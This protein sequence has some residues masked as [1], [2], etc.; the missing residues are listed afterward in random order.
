MTAAGDWGTWSGGCYA[1]TK[2]QKK[3]KRG[4]LSLG[5]LVRSHHQTMKFKLVSLSRV[6]KNG[7][8]RL[9]T[10]ATTGGCL[11]WHCNTKT[12][13]TEIIYYTALSKRIKDFFALM[14]VLVIV[15]SNHKYI[16]LQS[17]ICRE[18][19]ERRPK[20]HTFHFLSILW[21]WSL[22]SLLTPHCGL[23]LY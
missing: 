6:L 7:V 19:I 21:D 8:L 11:C 18:R 10:A 9:E 22:L 17:L 2:E 13:I 5:I 15:T 1:Y 16:V 12:K 23:G 14:M 4:S 3:K 20:K